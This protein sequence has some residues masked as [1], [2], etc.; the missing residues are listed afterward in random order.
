MITILWYPECHSYRYIREEF[1]P[2]LGSV[3]NM[4]V[5]EKSL[6]NNDMACHSLL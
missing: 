3:F 6:V 2:A 4:V 5:N 1:C